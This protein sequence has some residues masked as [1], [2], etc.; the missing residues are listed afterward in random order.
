MKIFKISYNIKNGDIMNN[1][2]REIIR[3]AFFSFD[4]TVDSD[5]YIS[6]GKVLVVRK[7]LG[8]LLGTH[9]R[10]VLL[11]GESYDEEDK[12]EPYEYMFTEASGQ[13][14][15]TEKEI[16]FLKHVL[17]IASTISGCFDSDSACLRC[18]CRML[19][20]V[21]NYEPLSHY[22][23]LYETEVKRKYYKK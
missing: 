10:E 16:K 15:L 8:E 13:E 11:P 12:N 1:E 23:L 21:T 22:G 20:E 6:M 14:D 4:V 5:D 3:Q 9:A 7:K 19:A 17:E 2:Q 18:A